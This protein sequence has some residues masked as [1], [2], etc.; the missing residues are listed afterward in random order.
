V[1]K[2]QQNYNEEHTGIFIVLCCTRPII[3]LASKTLVK[4][5]NVITTN[6]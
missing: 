4:L 1:A 3:M 5:L 6:F 2:T